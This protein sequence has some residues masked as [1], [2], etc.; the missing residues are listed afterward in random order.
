MR[1]VANGPLVVKWGSCTFTRV[2]FLCMLVFLTLCGVTASGQEPRHAATSAPEAELRGRVFERGTLTPLNGARIVT[3][4]GETATDDTGQFSLRIPAGENEVSVTL[5]GYEPLQRDRKGDSRRRRARRIQPVAA[6][7]IQE[8]LRLDGA[9]RSAPRRRA[10]HAARRGAASGAGHARRSLSRHRPSAG[11]RRA[12]HAPADLRHSRRQPRHQR[13]LPRRH[14]R[15]AAVPLRRRRRRRSSAPRR[16]ARLLPRRLRRQLRPL[17]RRHHRLRDARRARTDAPAHGEIELKLYDLSA[18]VETKLPGGVSVEAAGHYGFPSYLIHLFDNRANVSYWDF[19]LRADWKTLTVEAFGSYDYLTIETDRGR[20]ATPTRPAVPPTVSEERLDFYR[21]QIRDRHAFGRVETEA[22]LVG[23]YDEF[24][25]V[26]PT[27]CEAVAGVARQRARRAGSAS[28]STPASTA[29]CRA[30]PPATS[31]RSTGAD[32]PDALGELAGKRDGVESRRVRRGHARGRAAPLA[33]D[34]RRARR[35]L[36]RQRG[37][38]AR[39][40]SALRVSRQALAAAVHLR[41][42]RA[43]SAAAEL[44]HSAARRRHLRAAARPAARDSGGVRRRGRAAADGDASRSPATGSSSTTSTTRS[45]TSRR[46][47]CA[48]RR[49]P[50]RSSG[51]PSRITRQIDGHSY[52]MEILARKQAGRF[53][54]WIA[55]TLSRTERV[56]HAGCAPP[57]TIRR[58]CSTSCCRCG[59]RGT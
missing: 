5:E 9:R 59:C 10:L 21:L 22:A 40:R 36:S 50:S 16:Q 56:Y 34:G 42:H 6:A 25:A 1:T 27:V 31:T 13:L 45:S 29:R 30:S 4:S 35:R 37:D 39:R 51:F 55:Y 14:A 15:A 32:Q 28:A 17:R 3:P 12:D 48:P 58:T 2:K 18:L 46:R 43:L 57:T 20:P 41:R 24:E 52:G 19:Q 49:R 54:G 33:G 23:G 38:A 53:T 26:G 8:A 47:S 44:S 7:G 11:R